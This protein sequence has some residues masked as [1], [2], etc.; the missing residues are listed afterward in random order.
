MSSRRAWF[1]GGG[2]AVGL[3]LVIVGAV[4]AVV[5]YF[6]I[7]SRDPQDA[8]EFIGVSVP[9]GASD[10][11][12]YLERTSLP[13]PGP[14]TRCADRSFLMPT[15]GWKAYV[16]KYFRRGTTPSFLTY[17]SC[18][19]ASRQCPGNDGMARRDG[20]IVET[21]AIAISTGDPNFWPSSYDRAVVVLPDCEPGRTLVMWQSVRET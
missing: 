13:A 9:E 20:R 5:L 16:G 4:V 14:R 12:A 15:A 17:S 6:V 2:V 21:A 11:Q 18:N 3:I 7:P 10:V 1:V 19:S 8:A